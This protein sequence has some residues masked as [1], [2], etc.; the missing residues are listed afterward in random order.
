MDQCGQIA[1]WNYYLDASGEM[2]NFLIERRLF[3]GGMIY[4]LEWNGTVL[5][6]GGYPFDFGKDQKTK[7]V[8]YRVRTTKHWS[9]IEQIKKHFEKTYLEEI[10]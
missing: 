1:D 5:K 7:H 8:V 4:T 9:A 3:P 2:K 6:Y 10:E